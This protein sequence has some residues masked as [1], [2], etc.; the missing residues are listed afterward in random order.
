M[1]LHLC[2]FIVIALFVSGCGPRYRIGGETFS[3]TS[4][5]L[6]KQQELMSL[7]LAEIT[8]TDNHVGGTSLILIPSDV[9]IQNHYLRHGNVAYGPK[10]EDIDWL[11]TTTKNNYLFTADSIRKREIFDSIF[12]DL[13]NGNPSSYPGG[14]YDFV[15][16]VDVDGWYIKSKNNSRALRVPFENIKLSGTPRHIAILDLF[17]QQA[18]ELNIK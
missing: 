14:E 5:A 2:I 13:H 17:S 15:V 16:Y 6:T 9:E 8:P 18:R 1:K 4:E 11:V 10:K 7:Y 3:S 12:V